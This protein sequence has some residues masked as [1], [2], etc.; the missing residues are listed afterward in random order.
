MANHK[1]AEKRHRQSLKRRLR[2]R[3]T[4]T[5]LRTAVK[6]ARSAAEEKDAKAL[7]YARHA[8]TLLARAASKGILP[9]KTASRQ[10]GRITS[11]AAKATGS[12]PKAAK[13]TKKAK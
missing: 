11:A 1:S 10:I 5:T 12:A 7:E 6:K 3:I 13:A 2:N 8:E 9:K 4:K